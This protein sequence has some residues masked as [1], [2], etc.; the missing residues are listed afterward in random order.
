MNL[1]RFR[2]YTAVTMGVVFVVLLIT[3]LVLYLAPYGPGSRGWEW[4]GLTKHQYKEIH[5]YL[6]LFCVALAVFHGALNVKPLTKY[7]R[8]QSNLWGHPLVWA[9]AC[10]VLLVVLALF[11]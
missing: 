2:P 10:V 8:N 6:G 11:V 4:M 3:G 1:N 9:A 5:L 7:I